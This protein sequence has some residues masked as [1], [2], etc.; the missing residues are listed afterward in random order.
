MAK[1]GRLKRLRGCSN[2]GGAH[3]GSS[4]TGSSAIFRLTGRGRMGLHY[5]I[6]NIV[7]LTAQGS[8]TLW[9]AGEY[10]ICQHL[11][12]PGQLCSIHAGSS[13]EFTAGL[14]SSQP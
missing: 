12:L 8:A 13:P 9:L 4:V 14:Q 5:V 7:G 11:L 2:T 6:C 3:P 1:A 10:A